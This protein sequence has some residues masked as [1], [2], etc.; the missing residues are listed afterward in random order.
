MILGKVRYWL[1]TLKEGQA[2]VITLDDLYDSASYYLESGLDYARREDILVLAKE[3]NSKE[4][5]E[6]EIFEKMDGNWTLDR[7]KLI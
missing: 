7:R 4:Y 5:P 1:S 3:I 2:V 6:F